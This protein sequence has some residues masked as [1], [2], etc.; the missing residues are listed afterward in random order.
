M[1]G[2]DIS[3]YSRRYICE[4]FQ[5]QLL[6]E[7]VYPCTHTEGTDILLKVS[8]I[9]SACRADPCITT[10]ARGERLQPRPGHSGWRLAQ[11]V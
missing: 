4:S 6:P 3:V 8:P 11:A 10:S 9:Y 2:V 1:K 7:S 5:F